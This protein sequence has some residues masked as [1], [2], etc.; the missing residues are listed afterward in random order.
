MIKCDVVAI[1]CDYIRNFK[2]NKPKK[3]VKQ[4]Y[5]KM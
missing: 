3:N 1:Q 2:K 5:E 4:G